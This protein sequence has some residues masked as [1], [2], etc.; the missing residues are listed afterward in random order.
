[1]YVTWPYL[2]PDPIGRFVETVQ[3]MARHPWPG[4]VLFNGVTYSASGLPA[5]YMPVLLAIQFTEPVWILFAIG[6]A[7]A[8]IGRRP[9][10]EGSVEGFTKRRIASFE[11]LAFTL[12]WFVLPLVTFMIVRPTMYDNFRQSFFI[13]PPI[14]FMAGLAFDQIHKPVLQRALIALVVLPGLIASMKL[15]PYEYIYYNQFA[16]GVNSAAH[17][18]ELDYWGTSY[19]EAAQE[20]NRIAPPNA[21]VWVDGPAHILETYARPDFHLYSA[22]EAERADHY[23]AVVTLA[24][25]NQEKTSF[26]DACIAY[27]VTRDGAVLTVIKKP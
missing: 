22:Y 17:R 3:V 8:I 4:T 7:V 25:Y 5:S 15:H 14:F 11:L 9:A 24:R 2:W 21:N 1:M 27:A 16:G 20:L 6:L 26:P 12:V 10:A 13:V 23:D 18:F 19:R